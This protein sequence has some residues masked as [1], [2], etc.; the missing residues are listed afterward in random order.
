MRVTRILMLVGL[1]YSMGIGQDPLSNLIDNELTTEWGSDP[2]LCVR[3]LKYKGEGKDDY[4]L[5]QLLA[6]APSD[7]A[8][9]HYKIAR[10]RPKDD[11]W[12]RLAVAGSPAYCPG[13]LSQVLELHLAVRPKGLGKAA[14]DVDT[15]SFL[16]LYDLVSSIP[17]DGFGLPGIQPSAVRDIYRSCFRDS[18]NLFTA[19][20]NKLGQNP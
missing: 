16:A 5:Q 20:K 3:V 14:G 9:E 12:T 17:Q 4:A 13:N 18:T 11:F 10:T 15:S 6:G 8:K 2:E 7:A 19:V 1:T